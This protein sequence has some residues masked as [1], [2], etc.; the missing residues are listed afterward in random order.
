MEGVVLKANLISLEM[1]D[2]DVILGMDWLSNHQAS[3]NC[4]T[5]RKR[6]EKLGY[7]EFEFV[8]DRRVLPTCVIFALEVKRL[9]QKGCEAYIAHVID[10]LISEV[11]LKNVPMVCEFLDVFLDDLPGLPPDRELEFGIEVFLVQLPF[12]YRRIEWLQWN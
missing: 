3:M 10:T 6:F 11:N 9:R 8:G 1:D 7:P 5:K 4:F 2:F 12:L